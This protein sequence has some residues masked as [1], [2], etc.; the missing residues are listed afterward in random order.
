VAS[1]WLEQTDA[2]KLDCLEVEG[3]TSSIRRPLSTTQVST[4]IGLS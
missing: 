3:S 4:Q 2:A 1:Y